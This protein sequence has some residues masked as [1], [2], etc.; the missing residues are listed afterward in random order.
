MRYFLDTEFME[1]GS[2][3]HLELL[4]IGVVAEDGREFYRV[5]ADADTDQSNPWVREHVLPRLTWTEMAEKWRGRKPSIIMPIDQIRE[6]LLGF[7][8]NDPK[9][10]AYF[11]DYDWV[12]VCWGLIG[13]MADLPDHFPRYCHDLKQT[14]EMLGHEVAP[15]PESDDGHNALADARWNRDLYR[16]LE[17][18]AAERFPGLVV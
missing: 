11:A 9:F 2:V 1:N 4:S 13:A 7:V 8:G 3:G 10:Y 17:S 5:N 12:M 18:E 15:I 6:E 14:M 16:H